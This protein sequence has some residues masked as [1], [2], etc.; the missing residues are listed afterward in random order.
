MR[1]EAEEK[2]SQKETGK[3][4]HRGRTGDLGTLQAREAVRLDF[5]SKTAL[6]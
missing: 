6:K 3:Q 1:E 5:H 2:V 4:K